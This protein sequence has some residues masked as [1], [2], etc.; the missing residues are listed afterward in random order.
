M[1]RAALITA[2]RIAHISG[3]GFDHSRM[4]VGHHAYTHGNITHGIFQ[5]P[6]FVAVADSDFFDNDLAG[7]KAALCVERYQ[8]HHEDGRK[9]VRAPVLIFGELRGSAPACVLD[10]KLVTLWM[11]AVDALE[12]EAAFIRQCMSYGP[13]EFNLYADWLG[14]QGR[15]EEESGFCE[16]SQAVPAQLATFASVG[17]VRTPE[18][19]SPII[20]GSYYETTP[21]YQPR[22]IARGE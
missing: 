10:V 14:E 22:T 1:N 19:E 15:G 20:R 12:A 13:I 7:M 4:P 5:T 9:L 16:F 8:F 21:G 3:M 17:V 2:D 11:G 6:A 18:I